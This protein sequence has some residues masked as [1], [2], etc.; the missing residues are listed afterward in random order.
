MSDHQTQSDVTTPQEHVS[1]NTWRYHTDSEYRQAMIIR[2]IEYIKNRRQ[3]DPEYNEKLKE[4]W[5]QRSRK[6]NQDP[7]KAARK[8]EYNKQRYIKLREQKQQQI[9]VDAN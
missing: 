5:R 2:S 7:E 8:R 9:A 1:Y 4:E 6:Y 3:E